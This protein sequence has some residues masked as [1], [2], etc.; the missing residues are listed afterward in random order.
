LLFLQC[1][2]FVF[3]YFNLLAQGFGNP[4]EVL[5]DIEVFDTHLNVKSSLVHDIYI[6]LGINVLLFTG[7]LMPNWYGARTLFQSFF[8]ENPIGGNDFAH[9]GIGGGC[10]NKK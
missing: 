5:S 1:F 3:Q 7:F 2:N 9:H 8:D 10:F 4:G 6:L